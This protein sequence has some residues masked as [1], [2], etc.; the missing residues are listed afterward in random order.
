[1]EKKNDDNGLDTILGSS[2]DEKGSQGAAK[3]ASQTS[4]NSTAAKVAIPLKALI[5]GGQTS[6]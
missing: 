4:Q 3:I 6:N 2:T 5:F 1:M